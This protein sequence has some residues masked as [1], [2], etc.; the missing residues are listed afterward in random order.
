MTIEWQE[1]SND[2]WWTVDDGL[3]FLV[4]DGS[5]IGSIRRNRCS[6]YDRAIGNEPKYDWTG[7]FTIDSPVKF[8][9]EFS[10]DDIGQVKFV[11]ESLI[12]RHV[13]QQ[14]LDA[15]HNALARS[16]SDISPCPQCGEPVVCMAEGLAICR[17]C[18]AKGKEKP[19]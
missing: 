10:G 7:D 1:E 13:D 8:T 14:K 18:Y 17:D 4:L 12:H 19:Q 11:M 2:G 5:E 9:G 3:H 6:N 15:L 16:E